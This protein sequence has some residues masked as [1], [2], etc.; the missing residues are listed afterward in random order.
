[1][2]F[3]RI[4]ENEI[5]PV[6]YFGEGESLKGIKLKFDSFIDFLTE[7]LKMSGIIV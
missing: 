7:E 1:M 3:F 2:A 5:L 4:G 6:Y